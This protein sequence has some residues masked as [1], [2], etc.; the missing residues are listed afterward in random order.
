M[1]VIGG[2]LG[3]LK[4]LRTV[5]RDLPA[6]FPIPIA[7]VLHRHKDSDDSLIPLLQNEIQLTAREVVDKDSIQAG[8]VYISPSDYHLL[9]EPMYFSLSTD[10]PVQ[11]AR[12]SIDVLFESAADIFGPKAI[13]IVLTG[14]NRDGAQGAARIHRNGG[15]VIVQKPSTAESAVMPEAAIETV[16]EAEVRFL[17]EIGALLLKL[18][19]NFS[20]P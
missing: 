1:I 7:V 4:A 17:E 10:E 11:Y 6:S 16:P 12:P 13:C 2:S 9:V 18:A 20:P 15:I 3:G 14:A 8:H 19:Q 5:L